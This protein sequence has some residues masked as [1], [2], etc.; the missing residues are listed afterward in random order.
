MNGQNLAKEFCDKDIV[1]VWEGGLGKQTQL[2][3]GF[4]QYKLPSGVIRLVYTLAEKVSLG[5]TFQFA[6]WL[7]FPKTLLNLLA[8]FIEDPNFIFTKVVLGDTT[9]YNC[10]VLDLNSLPLAKPG[11]EVR[12]FVRFTHREVSLAHI[13]EWLSLYGQLTCESRYFHTHYF[14]LVSFL[15]RK[16]TITALGRLPVLTSK[17]TYTR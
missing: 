5:T 8:E 16:L 14:Y 10:K 9:R 2:L 12:V 15:I 1:D 4:A 3:T 7:L 6:I 17:T 13:D 11:D